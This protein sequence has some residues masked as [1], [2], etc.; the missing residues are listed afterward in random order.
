MMLQQALKKQ[1]YLVVVMIVGI[2]LFILFCNLRFK[3]E[4]IVCA[5]IKMKN[6]IHNL[7]Y[8]YF[9]K[10]FSATDHFI[11]RYTDFLGT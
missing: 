7:P 10:H 9:D 11:Y 6:K 1:N 3:Y 5:N 4:I 8:P 2:I